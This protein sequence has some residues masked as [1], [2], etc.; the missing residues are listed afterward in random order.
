[1]TFQSE[2]H[3]SPWDNY[4]S[5]PATSRPAVVA[6]FWTMQLVNALKDN[7]KASVML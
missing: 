6:Y 7:I 1:M 2:S 3:R 5:V 4:T